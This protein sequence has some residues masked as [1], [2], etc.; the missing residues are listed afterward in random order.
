VKGF[1]DDELFLPGGSQRRSFALAR[2]SHGQD[3]ASSG[4]TAG[5]TILLLS[6]ELD[7]KKLAHVA[8]HIAGDGTHNSSALRSLARRQYCVHYRQLTQ[9]QKQINRRRACLRVAQTNVY[10]RVGV[11][12]PNTSIL[13]LQK[14]IAIAFSLAIGL[15]NR[16]LP[17][18]FR[19]LV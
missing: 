8:G 4:V 9:R 2:S 10:A 11:A 13:G 17:Y 14:P 1:F 19:R 7:R 18:D 15:L 3:G 5:E 16:A 12:G 6:P